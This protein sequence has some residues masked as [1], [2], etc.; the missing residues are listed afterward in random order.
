MIEWLKQK[1]YRWDLERRRADCRKRSTE[2]HL[3]LTAED[4]D[5]L[6]AELNR[7]EV[8]EKLAQAAQ[9]R[10]AYYEKRNPR[11]GDV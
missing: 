3:Y 7:E 2:T 6:M 8:S 1:L 9:R 10:R 11:S 4:Y 5:N